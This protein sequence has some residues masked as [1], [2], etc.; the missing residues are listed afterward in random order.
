MGSPALFVDD[1][2]RFAQEA[3]DRVRRDH[4]M[5]RADHKLGA[6][7]HLDIVHR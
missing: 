4:K 7:Q 1:M 3:A 5:F 6:F 2:I